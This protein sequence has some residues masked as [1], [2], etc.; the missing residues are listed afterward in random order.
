MNYW[1]PLKEELILASKSPRRTEILKFASVPH[2]IKPSTVEEFPMEGSPEEIVQHWAKAK[3]LDVTG[4]FPDRPVLGA[5]TMVFQNSKLLGKPKDK[6]EAFQ[7]L[8]SLSG[9][10]HT[11]FGGVALFWQSRNISFVFAEP[12]RVKFREISSEE[13]RAYIATGEPMD[14]AGSYGIQGQGSVLVERIEGCYFNVM[15]LPIARF[16]QRFKD[17][18][19]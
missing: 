15:G 18:I 2:L 6:N 7:M 3:A 11:V 10:W 1:Y 14:K 17:S 9:E 12:T 8:T 16:L 4:K 5:D 19:T 13:I